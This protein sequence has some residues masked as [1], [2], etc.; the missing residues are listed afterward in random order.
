MRAFSSS[1]RSDA[2]LPGSER[3]PRLGDEPYHVHGH[4]N[5]SQRVVAHALLLRGGRHAALHFERDEPSRDAAASQRDARG[6]G[7][8]L[9]DSRSRRQVRER[10]RCARASH[11][12]PNGPH[13]GARAEHER[14]VRALSGLAAPRV[15]RPRSCACRPPPPA[16]R[17]RVRSLR[18]R[19]A[20]SPRD[21]PADPG[22][23]R[24]PCRGE[25]RRPTRPRG[26]PSRMSKGPMNQRRPPECSRIREV[27]STHARMA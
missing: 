4:A 6:C 13:R 19:R 18:L 16:R 2:T 11:R 7:A 25:H 5:R 23:R 12:H 26:P 1:A 14:P 10:L 20:P 17:R 27:A 8:T 22:P 24:A 9:F 3:G 15:P 21:P